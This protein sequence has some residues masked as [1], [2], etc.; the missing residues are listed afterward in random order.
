M[1][2]L[3][4]DEINKYTEI[5]EWLLSMKPSEVMEKKDEVRERI[6]GWLE[7]CYALGFKEARDELGVIAEYAIDFLP[8]DYKKAENGALQDAE[9]TSLDVSTYIPDDYLLSKWDALYRTYNGMDAMDRV[10]AYSEIG[11]PNAI[12]RV[13]ETDGHRI[14]NA[15]GELGAR[16]FASTKQWLT[17]GDDKVRDTHDYLEGMEVE[18]DEYFY[19][20]D[21]D[22][23]RYPGD[24]QD[25]KN[26]ANCRCVLKYKR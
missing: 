3:K 13:A 24:F 8:S 11:E 1:Q 25:I 20:Y 15:G 2:L 21:G 19:T 14:Y 18:I 6:F 9:T 12:L 5:K 16:G 23:A 26:N 7:Y 4:F 17:A 10:I 22:F